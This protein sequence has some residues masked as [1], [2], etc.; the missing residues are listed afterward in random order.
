M[1]TR[2]SP[3]PFWTALAVAGILCLPLAG[4]PLT[5]APEA[6]TSKPSK[7][8]RWERLHAQIV[9]KDAE[10][11][12]TETCALVGCHGD[13]VKSWTALPHSQHVLQAKTWSEDERSCEGCHGPGSAHLTDPRHGAIARLGEH[14]EY[15]AAL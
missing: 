13:T 7:P 8:T 14:P 9:V 3:A 11:A 1:H 4:V 15:V 2:R 5:A 12:G 6:G 10:Y